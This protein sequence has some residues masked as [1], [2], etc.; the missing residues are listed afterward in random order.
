MSVLGK[1]LQEYCMIVDSN[2]ADRFANK[3]LGCSKVRKDKFL[4]EVSEELEDGVSRFT[5]YDKAQ[6][7]IDSLRR[8]PYVKMGI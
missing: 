2:S 1:V 6:D 8:S 3:K 4:S 5:S 7:Y